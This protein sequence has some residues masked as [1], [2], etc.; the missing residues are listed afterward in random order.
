MDLYSWLEGVA[1]IASTLIPFFLIWACAVLWVKS[2]SLWALAAFIGATSAVVGAITLW[3]RFYIHYSSVAVM[4]AEDDNP[5]LTL[6]LAVKLALSIGIFIASFAL[7][8][9][10]RSLSNAAQPGAPADGLASLRSARRG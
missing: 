1:T 3:I 8:G 5:N 4:V 9:Y 10:A 7:V 6:Q 2:R